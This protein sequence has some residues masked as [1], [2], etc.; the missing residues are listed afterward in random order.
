MDFLDE[1]NRRKNA[2]KNE[3]QIQKQRKILQERLKS[4]YHCYM[5]DPVAFPLSDNERE[6]IKEVIQAV[7]DESWTEDIRK[8]QLPDKSI[9]I[10]LCGVD[11]LRISISKQRPRKVKFEDGLVKYEVSV[12]SNHNEFDIIFKELFLSDLKQS[13]FE[14]LTESKPD[15]V[16]KA[17]EEAM[18]FIHELPH[19]E[20]KQSI[21]FKLSDGSRREDKEW[22]V[23][24]KDGYFFSSSDKFPD[25]EFFIEWISSL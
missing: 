8:Y 22:C 3:A 1:V 10:A 11:Y 19:H 12:M 4:K 7:P 18:K 23:L 6:F 14:D 9:H 5:S 17:E 16:K 24:F 25:R 20:S 13:M 21:V 2:K 15:F